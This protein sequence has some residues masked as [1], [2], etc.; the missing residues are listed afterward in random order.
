MSLSQ[1]LRRRIV[2]AIEKKEAGKKTLATRFSVSLSTVKRLFKLKLETGD[3]KPRPHAGGVKLLIPD[4]D[5]KKLKDLVAEKP[6]RTIT[7]LR[8]QWDLLGG[9][10]VSHATMFRALKRTKL[11]VKKRPLG[12]MN[13]I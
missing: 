6:D 7:E 11:T 5:L 8:E 12:Q 10:K 1:D 3:I 2:S 9:E 4:P 13:V